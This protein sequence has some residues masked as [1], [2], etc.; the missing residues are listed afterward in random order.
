MDMN[1]DHEEVFD[2]SI[3]RTN[4]SITKTKNTSTLC[5]DHHHL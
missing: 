3:T 5:P 4:L 2:F 1:K